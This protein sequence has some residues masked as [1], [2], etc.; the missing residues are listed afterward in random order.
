ML[1]PVGNLIVFV[2]PAKDAGLD[3]ASDLYTIAPDGTGLTRVTSLEGTGFR[4]L[5]PS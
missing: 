3:G 5:Q 2:Q 1:G 4:A